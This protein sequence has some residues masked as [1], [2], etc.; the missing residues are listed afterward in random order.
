MTSDGLRGLKEKFYILK[1]QIS[2]Q[3]IF[4]VPNLFTYYLN[5]IKGPA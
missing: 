3:K 1:I 2:E 4:Y 5:Y